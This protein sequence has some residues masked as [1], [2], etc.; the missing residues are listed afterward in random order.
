MPCELFIL[1]SQ[2][3]NSIGTAGD[4]GFRNLEQLAFY[5]M[6]CLTIKLELIYCRRMRAQ[7]MNGKH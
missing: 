6:K 7:S 3:N 5:S 4:N 1:S 2:G